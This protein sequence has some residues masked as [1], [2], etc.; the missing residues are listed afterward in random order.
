MTVSA[1]PLLTVDRLT[2]RFGG[3]VAVEDLSFELYRGETGHER[4][5]AELDPDIP[6]LEADPDK[7]RQLLH[8]LI[9]NAAEAGTD[10]DPTQVSIYTAFEPDARPPRVLVCVDDD[11]P[12]FRSDMMHRVF[13]PYVT[14]KTSG[15][16]LGL[17]IVKKIA[18]EHG[19]QVWAE[20]NE[21]A[22]AKVTLR[23]PVAAVKEAQSR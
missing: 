2:K 13:E 23:L 9:K 8:N 16:G 11:G 6:I 1:D 7:L 3:L 10:D 12:G 14:T 15:S 22:G 19:G 5:A 20:N 17:A 21:S 18:E 4:I